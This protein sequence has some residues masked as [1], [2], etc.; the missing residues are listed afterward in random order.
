VRTHV[1]PQWHPE[2]NR[3]I[4]HAGADVPLTCR[5]SRSF[6]IASQRIS[7]PPHW[8]IA[9]QR[10]SP[11][12]FQR[13][14]PHPIERPACPLV[15]LT[16]RPSDCLHLHPSVDHPHTPYCFPATTCTEDPFPNELLG[17]ILAAEVW[18]PMPVDDNYLCRGKCCFKMLFLSTSHVQ[19][20]LV[21]SVSHVGTLSSIIFLLL[22]TPVSMLQSLTITSHCLEQVLQPR[23]YRH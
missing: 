10:S 19:T 16:S 12:V 21:A 1:T 7:L 3:R 17:N 15:H 6:E 14:T 11:P 4:A 20:T 22:A 13:R 23:T 8:Q 5:F 18:L 2:S 9:S